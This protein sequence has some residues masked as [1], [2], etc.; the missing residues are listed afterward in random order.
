MNSTLLP[1]VEQV[2]SLFPQTPLQHLPAYPVLYSPSC[3]VNQVVFIRITLRHI[4]EPP[5]PRFIQC[6][7]NLRPRLPAENRRIVV[8]TVDRYSVSFNQ[9]KLHCPRRKIG[10]L[11]IVAFETVPT[12]MTINNISWDSNEDILTPYPYLLLHTISPLN[13][14]S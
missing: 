9:D 8:G 5:A 3:L 13:C 1:P 12:Y 4:L 7:G 11:T 14:D 10:A 6:I 2:I